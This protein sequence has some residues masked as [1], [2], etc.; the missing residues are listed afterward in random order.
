MKHHYLLS[1]LFLMCIP[2]ISSAQSE[3]T[4][5]INS[6]ELQYQPTS[7]ISD[8]E[9]TS[10]FHT[11]RLGF[12]EDRRL[13]RDTYIEYGIKGQLIYKKKH[14]VE[15]HIVSV[16]LPLRI[17]QMIPISTRV[18]LEPYAGFGC[19]FNVIGKS[20]GIDLFN[21]GKHIGNRVQ[22]T[23]AVGI[24]CVIG[25]VYFG[26]TCSMDIT[27]FS[28]NWRHLNYGITLGYNLNFLDK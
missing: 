26:P 16:E 17:K 23:S 2:T 19:Q 13:V 1:L 6:F 20:G 3:L 7:V 24:N 14:G 21:D 4:N 11:F 18:R 22:L 9:I 28:K 15:S 12:V 27:Q 10:G 5:V 25:D 8:G